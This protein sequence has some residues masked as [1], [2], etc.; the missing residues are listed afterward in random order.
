MPRL[1]F[2]LAALFTLALPAATPAHAVDVPHYAAFHAW[3]VACDN[4][5][6]CEARGFDGAAHEADLRLLRAAGDA[7]AELRLTVPGDV[8]L[9]GLVLDGTPLPTSPAWSVT[10]Q[11]GETTMATQDA[12]AVAVF[13]QRART[14]HRLSF[15]AGPEGVPLDGLTAA[16][17]RIDDVQGREGTSTALLAPRGPG[18]PPEPPALPPRVR[19]SA[20]VGLA[21]SQAQ[22]LARTVRHAQAA[23][24]AKASCTPRPDEPDEAFALDA[25][26]ALVILPCGFGAY[27]GD[28]LVFIVTRADGRAD[29]FAPRLPTLA[30]PVRTLVNAGFDPE[31]GTLSMSARGR[32][33]ADCGM[34]AEWVWADGGFVLV[35]MARQDACGGAEPGDWPILF[36]TAPDR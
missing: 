4:L 5:R 26:R 2:I 36:R 17:M 28:A 29:R 35:S 14:G 1:L 6:S 7:P 10:R 3:F 20:P 16:L 34:M 27:Q 12:A 8:A 33:M 24:L 25:K 22:S 23:A 30:D 31:T 21:S 13:L 11:D 32:G 9:A 18:S 19:W 15:G